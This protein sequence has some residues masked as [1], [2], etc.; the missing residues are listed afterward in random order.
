MPERL[1]LGVPN[2]GLS[3]RLKPRRR[4]RI[5]LYVM[6][7]KGLDR[8]PN[9]QTK[10]GA[11]LGIAAAKKWFSAAAAAVAGLTPKNSNGNNRKKN[12]IEG[13]HPRDEKNGCLS[14]LCGFSY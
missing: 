13:K 8:A 1:Q 12:D 2:D 10:G 5:A 9:W 7:A 14:P 6:K 4:T 11:D 3:H